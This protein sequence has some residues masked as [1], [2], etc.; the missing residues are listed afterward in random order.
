MLLWFVVVCGFFGGGSMQ[1]LV[2]L[3]LYFYAFFLC[4]FLNTFVVFSCVVPRAAKIHTPIV[5]KNF[6]KFPPARQ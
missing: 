5:K 4:F 6:K 3:F 2:R 1:N